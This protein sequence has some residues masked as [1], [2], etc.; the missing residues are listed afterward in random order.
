M[1]DKSPHAAL[2][3]DHLT[4]NAD[5]CQKFYINRQNSEFTDFEIVVEGA[6]LPCHRMVLAAGS[7]YFEAVLS[8]DMIEG[9]HGTV[10]LEGITS[11]SMRF[12]LNF[13]TEKYSKSSSDY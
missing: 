10:V 2:S 8:N 13:K 3:V 4:H 7:P 12:V 6:S 5:L 11:R 1:E 9:R